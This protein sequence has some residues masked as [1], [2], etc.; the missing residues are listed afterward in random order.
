MKDVADELSPGI[1]PGEGCW[2]SYDCSRTYR[3]NHCFVEYSVRWFFSIMS[4]ESHMSQESYSTNLV[5]GSHTTLK[6]VVVKP[7]FTQR[8]G[9]APPIN[10]FVV[11]MWNYHWSIQKA[12]GDL[13]RKEWSGGWITSLVSQRQGTTTGGRYR[14][15]S[16]C[17]LLISSASV[18]H[19]ML[20]KA[21]PSISSSMV[22]GHYCW[23]RLRTFVLIECLQKQVNPFWAASRSM[24]TIPV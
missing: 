22:L 23:L 2:T 13:S 7:E 18:S 19:S 20:S 10:S 9:K 11:K 1:W 15:C 8:R 4:S 3:A 14:G 5:Q 21:R 6:A 24:F 16:W 17:R 12:Q